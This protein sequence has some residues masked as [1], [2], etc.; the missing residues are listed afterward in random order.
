MDCKTKTGLLFLMITQI[1]GIISGII[2]YSMFYSIDLTNITTENAINMFFS[3]MP[4]AIIGGIGGFIGLIGAIFFLIGRK[5]FGEKHQKFVF[6]AIII[7]I[8]SIVVTAILG[9]IMTLS[10]YSSVSSGFGPSSDHSQIVDSLK[11]AMTMTAFITLITTALGGL[12][13]VF[14]LYQLENKNGRMALF[15]ALIVMIVVS[16]ITGFLSIAMFNDYL[17][18]EAFI[19]LV[20]SGTSSLTSYSQYISSYQW[21]GPSAIISLIGNIISG[22]LMFIALYIP[23]QRIKSGVLLP[24][25]STT[26]S[27]ES[28]RK[29][30]NCNRTIPFDA[31]VCPYCNKHFEDFL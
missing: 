12:M 23:Y 25:I 29:C 20:S 11:I 1:A 6:Y 14:A 4:G 22:V 5:E 3:M 9:G 16:A 7:F 31:N 18:S 28:D 17:N 2:M 15:V 24:I 30:P 26:N 8:T 10:T 13:W 27:G 19:D 21:I